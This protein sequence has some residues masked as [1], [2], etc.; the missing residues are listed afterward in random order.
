M[1][2]KPQTVKVEALKY[3]T[4]FG[5]E[6]QVGD[7]YD[8]DEQFLDSVVHQGLAVP[9]DRV[10]RAK[11]AEKAAKETVKAAA[12]PAAKLARKKASTSKKK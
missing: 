12:K 4:A 7:T 9:V 5:S 1:A 11:Q 10:A 3:H 8:L 2:D 6:Y